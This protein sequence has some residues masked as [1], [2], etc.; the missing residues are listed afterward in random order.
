MNYN[1]SLH[2]ID[3]FLRPGLEELS[4]GN[5]DTQTLCRVMATLDDIENEFCTSAEVSV[6]MKAVS[7]ECLAL[8]KASSGNS[9]ERYERRRDRTLQVL[10]YLRAVIADQ[11]V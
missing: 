7:M 11:Q 1:E 4:F 8:S 3:H 6:V 5:F 10:S 9:R 2:T